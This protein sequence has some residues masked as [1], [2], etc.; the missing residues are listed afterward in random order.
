MYVCMYVIDSLFCT[1]ET[2]TKLLINYTQIFKKKIN[3]IYIYQREL[4]SLSSNKL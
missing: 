1:L 2:I 4:Y 3:K